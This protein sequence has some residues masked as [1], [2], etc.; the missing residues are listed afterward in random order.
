MKVYRVL[1]GFLLS[2]MFMTANAMAVDM[3]LTD[4]FGKKYQLEDYRGKWLVLNYWA[5]WCPPCRE[6]I[7]MLVDYDNQHKN[8]QVMGINYEP[9]IEVTEL[10]EF[11]DNYFV[12]YP[13]IMANRKIINVF[14]IPKGLPMTVFVDPEGKIVKH[15]TGLLN[16]SLLNRITQKT[17]E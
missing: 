9:G 11:V 14:G 17:D 1:F 5:T 6:E 16:E 4:I 10:Q 13:N 3:E 8:V 2:I 7:P 15:Y 12:S